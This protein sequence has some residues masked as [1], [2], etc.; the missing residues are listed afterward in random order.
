MK[1]IDYVEHINKQKL[2]LMLC[3]IIMNE[4]FFDTILITQVVDL[5][6]TPKVLF[7]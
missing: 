4:I 6:S 3:F 1:L 2:I 7:E 5:W